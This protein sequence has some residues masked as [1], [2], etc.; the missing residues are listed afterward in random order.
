MAKKW[1]I[2]I[3][4][5]SEGVEFINYKKGLISSNFTPSNLDFGELTWEEVK[6]FYCTKFHNTFIS[7]V[8]EAIRK[9]E[10]N[11]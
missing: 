5:N 1:K 6:E 2:R 11:K 8:K 7:K 4:Q 10:S 3:I 9:Y